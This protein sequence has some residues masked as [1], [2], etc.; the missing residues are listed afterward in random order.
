MIFRDFVKYDLEFM[1][2]YRSNW[3]TIHPFNLDEFKISINSS[4]TLGKS[5]KGSN[6]C[7]GKIE[8]AWVE[9]VKGD[10]IGEWVK[11]SINAY[12]SL[13]QYTTTPFFIYRIGVVP[14]YAKSMKTWI[15]NNRV[16]KLLVII[17]SPPPLAPHEHEWVVLRLNLKD[18]MKV[19]LFDIPN[20]KQV[21]NLEPMVKEIWLKIEEVYKGTKYD[22]TCISEF[23]AIGGFSS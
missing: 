13:A 10:G 7:D 23:I 21:G 6:I 19:Q 1:K 20:D 2:K 15:E 4:S 17:H 3:S 14:G 5:Y 12:S 9:G 8:T 22:D 11:I 18:E 16:K